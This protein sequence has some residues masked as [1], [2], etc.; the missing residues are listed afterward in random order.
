[1]SSLDVKLSQARAYS[2]YKTIK[3][4]VI[5]KGR[6]DANEYLEDLTENLGS[7]YVAGVWDQV[8]EVMDEDHEIELRIDESGVYWQSIAKH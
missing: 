2:V 4:R 5:S 1:M 3:A 7:T 6:V 8:M